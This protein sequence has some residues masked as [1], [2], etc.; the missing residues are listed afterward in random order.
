MAPFS[1]NSDSRTTVRLR[2]SRRLFDSRKNGWFGAC[3]H[4]PFP[5]VMIETDSSR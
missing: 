3:S 1:E 2:E 4:E 5:C